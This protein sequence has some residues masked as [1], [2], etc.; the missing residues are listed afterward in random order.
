ML[1]RPTPELSLFDRYRGVA[2]TSDRELTLYEYVC[3]QV[4]KDRYG[5]LNACVQ[6]LIGAVVH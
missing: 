3:F 5:S 1:Y 2:S 4:V 6:V